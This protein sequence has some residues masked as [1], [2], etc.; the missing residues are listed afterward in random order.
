MIHHFAY[1]PARKRSSS[2]R[3]ASYTGVASARVTISTSV[4]ALFLKPWQQFGNR[5]GYGALRVFDLPVIAL[6]SVQKEQR[7]PG[8]RGIYHNHLF[9]ALSTICAN[10][11]NTAISCV[12]GE[13][14]SSFT[15]ARSSSPIVSLAFAK[16]SSLYF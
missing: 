1:I 10:A 12:H 7:M 15:Y 16:T 9:F 11:L 5:L 8:W 4:S 6:G 14:R 2:S 13:R 3:M